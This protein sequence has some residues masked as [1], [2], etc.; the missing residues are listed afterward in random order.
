MEYSKTPEINAA[1]NWWVELISTKEPAK[2]DAG[3]EGL[4]DFFSSHRTA[5]IP[6]TEDE[7]KRFGKA[8]TAVLEREYPG[9][10]NKR[11]AYIGTDYEPQEL[12]LEAFET[13]LLP[14][15]R[16]ELFPIKTRTWLELG[17]FIAKTGYRGAIETVYPK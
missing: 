17:K 3:D 1:V 6:A 16:Q 9:K 11:Y 2:Y 15:T 13:A 12:L 8:L 5:P 4:N 7:L 14:P 10:D